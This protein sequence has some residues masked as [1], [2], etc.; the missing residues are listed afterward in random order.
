MNPMPTAYS[1]LTPDTVLE[2]LDAVG[3][4]GDGRILQLNSY[5]NRVFRLMLEDGGAVVAKFYRPGRWSDAQIHEEH[6]F[7]LELAAA[8]VAVMAPLAMQLLPPAPA[9][10]LIT[11]PAATLLHWEP[12]EGG[13]HRISVSPWLGG[14]DPDIESPAAFERLGRL[15]GRV[16]ALGATRP[17]GHRLTLSPALGLQAVD[18]LLAL[19]VVD[20]AQIK[21]WESA[22]RTAMEGVAR[23]F[24]QVGGALLRLHGD[25]HRGNLLEREQTLHLV[26]FDDACNGP[27]MQDLWL[28]LDGHDGEDRRRQL[29]ALLRGYEDF[30]DFDDA[31]VRLIEPLRTLRLLRHSAWIAQRWSDPA[32]P[33]AFPSFGT[34]NH[35][36]DQTV[37]LHEQIDR[38]G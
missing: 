34:P 5:E 31:Q 30:M 20:L 27:A 18:T 19:Q 11:G 29:Q 38:M 35:W 6:V 33:I 13:A 10:A 4:R 1:Q 24:E 17:F 36:A 7:T 14:R 28:F 15:I 12:Q 21:G 2:A 25:A 8:E 16:H 9:N 32:F 26:D 22:A 23:A 37:L 3:L